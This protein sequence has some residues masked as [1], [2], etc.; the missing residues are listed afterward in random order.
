MGSSAGSTE[1]PM[2]M[3]CAGP[4][5]SGQL[6]VARSRDRC[7]L[8]S[9]PMREP[10]H[11]SSAQEHV[12]K[13]RVCKDARVSTPPDRHHAGH[14]VRVRSCAGRP[15]RVDAMLRPPWQ[16][17]TWAR[18][19]SGA[20]G[21]TDRREGTNAVLSPRG[22]SAPREPPFLARAATHHPRSNRLLPIGWR[23]RQGPSS[24]RADARDAVV[25]GR[26]AGVDGGR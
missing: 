8:A 25:R 2:E 11:A 7:A 14:P 24:A 6:R 5:C 17:T 19:S 12:G 4:C 1:L 3:P 16:R 21:P 18:L 9:R 22:G 15:E 13:E 26:A 10:S 23:S 20:E